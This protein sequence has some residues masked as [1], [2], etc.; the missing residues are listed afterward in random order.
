MV[1]KEI[2]RCTEES[3]ASFLKEV[4]VCVHY[5][6]PAEQLYVWWM[7]VRTHAHTHTHTHTHTHAHTHTRMHAH[8]YIV[9]PHTLQPTKYIQQY[10]NVYTVCHTP[11]TYWTQQQHPL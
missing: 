2:V 1:M 5:F 11:H 7:D 6:L 9:Q 10:I 4:C 3:K 8:M